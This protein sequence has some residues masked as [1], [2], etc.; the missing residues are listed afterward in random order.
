MPSLCPDWAAALR[1][2]NRRAPRRSNVPR[3]SAGLMYPDPGY[4]ASMTPQNRAYAIAAWLSV[5]AA[6]CGQMLYPGNAQKPVVPASAWRQFFWIYRRQPSS[7]LSITPSD[8]G[9]PIPDDDLDAAAKAAKAMFGTDMATAMNKTTCEVFWRGRAYH[10]T[11]GAVQG[12][13]HRVVQE[14]LWEL[15]ELNWRY[16][17]LALDRFAAP[18]MWLEED[19]AGART[20]AI[21][22]VFVP[23]ASLVFTHSPFPTE[24]AYIAAGNHG[25]RL[26]ALDALR[27]V[28]S[29]WPGCPGP[30]KHAV[31]DSLPSSSPSLDT[32]VIEA[33]SMLFYCQTFYDYFNRPPILPCMLPI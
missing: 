20:S 24:N 33:Q 26:Q 10:V 12:M 32:R 27:R 31:S 14:I 1:A 30:I 17:V 29:D 25:T 9:A 5:R 7:S 13:E 22:A 19:T 11:D 2:V 4:M 21:L 3:A 15:A 18:H 6:R 28:M 23:S 16:E 8:T